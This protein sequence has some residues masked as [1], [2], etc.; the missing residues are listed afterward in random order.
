MKLKIDFHVH[1][2][3]SVDGYD[4][5][6]ELVRQAKKKKL[7]GICVCDHNTIARE[8]NKYRDF[9]VI[10]GQEVSTHE[11]HVLVLGTEFVYPKGI[12]LK[13]LLNHTEKTGALCIAAHP[14]AIRKSGVGPMALHLPFT[15]IEKFNGSDLFHN[16]V[17]MA[18]VKKGTGGSDA[19][20]AIEVGGAYTIVE[21]KNKSEE[22]VLEALKQGKVSA[23]WKP[24]P[25]NL[26]KRLSYRLTRPHSRGSARKKDA[27]C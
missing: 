11:G 19:H 13:D 1:S 2:N 16:V 25:V 15:A 23:V 12:L 27:G 21:A 4:S 17:S 20:A 8:R 5:V 22:A 24:N 6:D 7:D 10:Y 14:F 26:L 9:I 18:K 3:Y